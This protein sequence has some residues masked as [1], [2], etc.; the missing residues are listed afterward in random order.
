MHGY[1][2]IYVFG[3]K[4]TIAEFKK[5]YPNCTFGEVTHLKSETIKE[6]NETYK[7]RLEGA[8]STSMGLLNLFNYSELA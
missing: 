1:N 5:Q 7:H 2:N 6:G 3:Q 8:I 4:M